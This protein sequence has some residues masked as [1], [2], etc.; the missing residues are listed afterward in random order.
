MNI[1]QIKELLTIHKEYNQ[2]LQT[3]KDEKKFKIRN[4]NFP[5]AISE[6][7]IKE[8]INIIEKR[9]CRKLDKSGDLEILDN[10]NKIKVEVKCFSSNGPTSFG[11]NESWDEL[12]FLD[13][14]DFMNNNF[15][16]YKVKLSSKSRIFGKIKINSENTFNDIKKL[17]K[18]PRINFSMLLEQLF[19]HIS[20]LYE[21]DI[22]FDLEK[23]Q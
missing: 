14:T 13:A 8:Y 11:P 5:E 17:K 12:Y 3:F 22:D 20:L 23:K 21:G 9:D 6:N 2:S 1:Q 7:I 15:K 10:N 4:P 19:N 18:R 16:I